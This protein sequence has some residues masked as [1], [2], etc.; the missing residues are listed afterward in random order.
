MP[1]CL[2]WGLSPLDN[3]KLIGPKEADGFDMDNI[4]FKNL[5]SARNDSGIFHKQQN[6]VIAQD[7]PLLYLQDLDQTLQYTKLLRTGVFYY[8]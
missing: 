5:F 6:S 4:V 7:R 2:R 8:L 1:L 3:Q